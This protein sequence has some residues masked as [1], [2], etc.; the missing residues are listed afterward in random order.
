MNRKQGAQQGGDPW[1]RSK[2]EPMGLAEALG[3][4]VKER[5]KFGQLQ[6]LAGAAGRRKG[7]REISIVNND[8]PTVYTTSLNPMAILKGRK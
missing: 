3:V 4:D 7:L 1:V 6:V 5:E 2:G 8:T